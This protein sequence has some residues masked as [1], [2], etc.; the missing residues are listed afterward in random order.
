MMSEVF[1]EERGHKIE[2]AFAFTYGPMAEGAP[3][4]MGSE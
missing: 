4:F 3:Y 1:V 2:R